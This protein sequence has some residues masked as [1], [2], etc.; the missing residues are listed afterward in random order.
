M[1]DANLNLNFLS[2]NPCGN[3]KPARVVTLNAA[4]DRGVVQAN[5]NSVPFGI[6]QNWPSDG[7]PG[8]PW[9]GVAGGLAGKN[10]LQ[11]GMGVWAPASTCP[12]ALKAAAPALPC[13]TSVGP[14]A[15]GELIEV[16]SGWAVGW[17]FVAG[18]AGDQ[19][20]IQIFVFPH[21]LGSGSGS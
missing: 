11:I 18:Q 5:Q 4:K 6:A 7:P 16:T 8:T 10:D 1:A 15:N 3:I 17:V 21:F 13:G 20:V 19:S 12:A 14:D 9:Q 2:L